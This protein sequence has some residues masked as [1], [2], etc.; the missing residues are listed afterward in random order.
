M[1]ERLQRA[2]V[3]RA[4]DVAD[5]TV[6]CAP[7]G[8]VHRLEGDSALLARALLSFLT[9]P[10]DRDAILR[11]VE[12]LTGAPLSDAAVVDQLLGL[13][14][15]AGAVVPA[16]EATPAARPGGGARVVLCLSGAV[17]AMNAPSLV[18]LL[19]RA[20]CEVQIAATEHALRFV[21]REALEAL[22]HR[23]VS[24]GMFA[25]DPDEPVEHLR[26]ARWADVVLVWPATA[27]TIS[28][29]ATGDY[30]SIVAAL[31]LT[32]TCPVIVA[33]SMNAGMHAATAVQRN[34]AQLI[35]D[36]LFVVHPAFGI[37]VADA[38]DARD[39]IL[40]PA[41]PAPVVAQ[42]VE[43]VLRLP[44]GQ[45]PV[46]P[47]TAREWDALYRRHR[48]DELPWHRDEVDDDLVAVLDERLSAP[49]SILDAG[50]GLGQVARDLAARGHR[51][52]AT[53]LSAVALERA[54]ALAD[55]V[56]VIWLEDDVAQSK[57]AGQ[58]DAIVDRGCLHVLPPHRAA[59][60]AREVTRLVRPGGLLLLK[61][62]AETAC[63]AA[64][65]EPYDAE[66]LLTL[67]GQGFTLLDERESSIPGPEQAP[68]ARLFVLERK[69]PGASR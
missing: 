4:F 1:S 47:R 31:A 26:L 34:I 66:R 28:R 30:S 20:G 39:A 25:G 22:T 61:V 52:V 7:S 36:G 10:R 45:R 17:A 57:L 43:V 67:L 29:L 62:H 40:G 59:D 5:S 12:E 37:E 19:L 23:P 6:I 13:L 56:T 55:G 51:V 60:Y 50:C 11:H 41:P 33:P 65:T 3:I 27:T 49:A 53:D 2:A 44:R 35:D 15:A 48:P 68:A 32:A 58:F 64:G 14:R 69:R 63:G 24:A 8:K 46:A 9:T 38:P 21:R 18:A 54:S 16:A 42:L